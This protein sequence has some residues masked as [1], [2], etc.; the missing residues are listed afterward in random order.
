MP[1]SDGQVDK[2]SPNP[3]SCRTAE[4]IVHSQCATVKGVGVSA[5]PRLLMHLMDVDTL[6][7]CGLFKCSVT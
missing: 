1:K 6:N 2:D 7:A 3:S 4:T 5:G